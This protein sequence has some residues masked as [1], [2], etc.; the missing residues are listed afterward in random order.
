MIEPNATGKSNRPRTSATDRPPST[1]INAEPLI[2]ILLVDDHEMFSQSLVRLLSDDPG[3]EV[4][5][6]AASGAEALLSASRSHPDIILMDYKLGDVD[7]ATATS[8]LK[9][10]DPGLKVIMLTGSDR[11]GAYQAAKEAGC[12][13]WL[14]KTSAVQDLRT[15]I[16]DVHLGVTPP[17]DEA[18][19]LPTRDQLVVHYQPV[20]RMADGVV[21]G[22]EA[23]VRWDH[24][25]RGL[26]GPAEFL[27]LAEELGLM[28]QIGDWVG[29]QAI[30][31]IS[32]WQ[33]AFPREPRPWIAVNLSASGL[34]R[35]GM[36]DQIGNTLQRHRLAASDLVLEVTETILLEQ[37][38]DTL[39]RLTQLKSLGLNLALDDFG[40]GFSS[41]A[42]L[43][44][45]PFDH[46]KIDRSFVA[47]LVRSARSRM[48]VD[49]IS[50]LAKSLRLQTVA[51]G[52]ERQDQAA[53]VKEAGVTFGQG[54]L[55]SRPLP[56]TDC[57]AFLE[58]H[59]K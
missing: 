9:D 25:S 41:L 37:S 28:A 12:A 20:V 6:T 24:P 27:P 45:F 43:R 44:E 46:I 31:E 34:R 11:P 50:E 55:Y 42:Y 2:R 4:I 39:R 10:A 53:V 52:I 13:A 5:G 22:F 14:R 15:A 40:T 8:R 38:E 26:V 21:A 51:E 7:G 36:A 48:L 16:Y 47:D 35:D 18:A 29:D 23:L 54:Y 32:E 59:R 30:G 1:K 33:R 58:D 3:I 57:I 56:A 19:R 17:D 49:S